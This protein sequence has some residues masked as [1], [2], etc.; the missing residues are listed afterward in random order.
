VCSGLARRWLLHHHEP[1]SLAA[2]WAGGD[3]TPARPLGRCLPACHGGVLH[4]LCPSTTARQA[5]HWTKVPPQHAA[6]HLHRPPSFLCIRL[7]CCSPCSVSSLAQRWTITV[8]PVQPLASGSSTR[9]CTSFMR[10]LPAAPSPGSPGAPGQQRED[11]H[12]QLLSALVT[13]LH[14]LLL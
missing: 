13:L 11:T 2:A 10:S 3:L 5:A 9:L 12:G 14:A 1:D 6:C 4:L 8:T 7:S